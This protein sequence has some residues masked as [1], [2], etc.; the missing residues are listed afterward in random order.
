MLWS[1]FACDKK[2]GATKRREGVRFLM[3][4]MWGV[5]F[6]TSQLPSNASSCFLPYLHAQ[7]WWWSDLREKK[8]EKKRRRKILLLFLVVRFRSRQICAKEFVQHS[9]SSSSR[10]GFRSKAKEWGLQ[11]A[12]TPVDSILWSDISMWIPAEARCLCGY[13]SNPGHP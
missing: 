12:S 7:I 9:S 1:G 6:L 2:Y 11:D 5:F 3:W 4:K 10:R 8:R 13:D